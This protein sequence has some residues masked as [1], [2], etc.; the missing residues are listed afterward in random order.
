MERQRA[1]QLQT[2]TAYLTAAAALTL[3][4][5]FY[6]A[7][8]WKD[9]PVLIGLAAVFLYLQTIIVRIGERSDYSLATA[10]VLPIVYIGGPTPAMIISCLAGLTDG[11][12]HKKGWTRTLFNASQLPAAAFVSGVLYR[13]LQAHLGSSGV[14]GLL[15]MVGGAVVYMFINIA[16]VARMVAFFRRSSWLTQISMLLA[17]SLRS[18]LSSLLMGIVFTYFVKAYGFWGV[19]A[20]GVLMINLSDMLKAAV[21][22]SS[23]RAMRK[24][25]EEALLCDGMTG[26]FNFRFLNN[27]LH[28]HTDT[29]ETILFVDIDDFSAFNNEYGHAAGDKALKMLVE[30][31]ARSVRPEDKLVRYGG[32]EFVVILKDVGPEGG[33]RIAE[34]IMANLKAVKEDEW[35]RPVTISVGIASKPIHTSDRHQLLLFSDQ[36]MYAAKAAGKNALRVWTPE[37]AQAAAALDDPS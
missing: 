21:E 12:V 17:R 6:D 33:A 35:G 28:E 24:E 31:I 2:M 10:S 5:L 22:V 14:F 13:F 37:V 25:L 27:W 32:D 29:A 16:L 9:W 15:A 11:L 1:E 26:A 4:V 18:S 20:F 30:T 19:V 23:E 36:A 7:S 3:G 34:R 8:G